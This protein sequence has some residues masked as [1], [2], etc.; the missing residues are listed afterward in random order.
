VNAVHSLFGASAHYREAE[1]KLVIAIRRYSEAV[2]DF[3]AECV[4]GNTC[5]D[6]I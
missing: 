4:A 1:E 3:T 6:K 2:G 5:G